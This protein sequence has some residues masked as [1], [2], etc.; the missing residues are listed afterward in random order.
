MAHL[1]L[2]TWDVDGLIIEWIYKSKVGKKENDS[3][4]GDDA[5]TVALDDND[6]AQQRME[7]LLETETHEPFLLEETETQEQILLE[8]TV[9]ID[10]SLEP[11][12]EEI[13]VNENAEEQ[14]EGAA[15]LWAEDFQL[16]CF[17]NPLPQ[18]LFEAIEYQQSGY[19]D[20]GFIESN[21][22]MPTTP[23][24][25]VRQ[26]VRV[27]N[28][29]TMA[30]GPTF[31][32]LANLDAALVFT[33]EEADCEVCKR[34]VDVGRGIVLKGCHHTFCRRCLTHAIKNKEHPLMM[35]PSK[36]GRCAGE[37][38][39]D[40][41]K[42]LLTPEEYENYSFDTFT[43]A[44][45]EIGVFEE[46]E[47][48]MEHYEYV[49]NKKEFRCGICFQNIAPADGITL[50]KC[51][52]EFC[53]TCLGRYIQNSEGAT[54]PCPFRAEDGGKC[55]GILMDSEI[56][57]L[58]PDAFYRTLLKRSVD[59]AKASFPNAYCCKTPGC[60]V[61]VDNEGIDEFRCDGCKRLNCVKCEAVHEGTTCEN[62]QDITY[63]RDRRARE[64][65]L[66]DN[67][68]RGL[69][70]KKEAQLCPRCGI[71]TERISGCRHMI[72]TKCKH[73][74]EWQI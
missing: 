25:Q 19:M 37:V 70:N 60:P 18:P 14:Y 15:G 72:C 13:P 46:I 30:C 33:K 6:T 7:A 22:F 12:A 49:E 50:K 26:S 20:S 28:V 47:N 5:S 73:E 64:L 55:V 56:R 45:I 35:C 39:D 36:S 48:L 41:I 27:Q 43:N 32:A 16:P 61:W 1:V 2:K 17:N 31:G 62:Y 74:F 44:L 34:S 21:W 52:H 9:G 38:R 71:L 11:I 10:R 59:E 40:E 51:I 54:V 8:E 66:T 24:V 58:V 3:E 23:Q 53:K 4:D 29:I 67:Q 69:M 42:A 63:G 68:V 57:S 65:V